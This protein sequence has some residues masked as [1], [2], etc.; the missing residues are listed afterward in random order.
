MPF[1]EGQSVKLG[2]LLLRLDDTKLAASVAEADANFKLSTANHERARQLLRD[3][4]IS[5]QEYEQIAAQFQA[6]QAS[7]D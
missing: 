5:Q 6:T 7:L 4:L 3:K 1:T 2:D